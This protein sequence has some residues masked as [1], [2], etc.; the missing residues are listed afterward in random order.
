MLELLR[1]MVDEVNKRGHL[2][3]LLNKTILSVQ[4]LADD[5]QVSLQIDNG[6]L[7]VSGLKKDSVD[8]SIVGNKQ[9]IEAILT[10]KRKLRKAIVAQE[11]QWRGSMRASLL[12]ESLF[13]LAI[14]NYTVEKTEISKKSIDLV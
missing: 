7:Q 3:P 10:G 9:A 1:I 14:P 5:E 11:V 4:L 13:H 2:T 12:L 8:V 6:M